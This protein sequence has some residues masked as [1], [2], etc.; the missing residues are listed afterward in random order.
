MPKLSLETNPKMK[1]NEFITEAQRGKV[2][3]VDFQPA[4]SEFG[5]AEYQHALKSACNHINKKNASVLAFFNGMDVGIYDTE[6]EVYEHYLEH[7]LDPY[8]NIEFREKGY[9]F[10]R[11]WMDQD[12]TPGTIIKVLRA[13]MLNHYNDSRDFER[14]ELEEIVGNE[15]EDSLYD[16]AIYIPDIAIAELNTFNNALIGG[17]GRSECLHEIEILMSA[18]NI[19]SKEVQEWMYG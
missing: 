13:M 15:W 10:L 19:R 18:Y 3:L 4:Y 12:V 6:E 14:E 9:A 7:G 17:G 8:A 1:A 11:G 2:I 5:G 16:D